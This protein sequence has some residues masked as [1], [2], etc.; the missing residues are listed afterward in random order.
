M[1]KLIITLVLGGILIGAVYATAASL[2][3][4]VDIIGSGSAT[5]S[6]ARDVEALDW[7]VDPTDATV[8]IRAELTLGQTGSASDTIN[9]QILDDA[10]S[11]CNSGNETP[12]F[13]H[14]G[15]GTTASTKTFFMTLAA[16]GSGVPA[17]V[18]V[19]DGSIEVSTID[20]INITIEQ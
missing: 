17:A 19:G 2:T 5:V 15:T 6:G 16:G 14:A 9:F 13:T 20:C 1:K 12:I 10:D 3:I 11:T 18:T 7:S 8:A 4:S